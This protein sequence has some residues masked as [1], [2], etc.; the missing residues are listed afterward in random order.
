MVDNVSVWEFG[1]AELSTLLMHRRVQQ[2][3]MCETISGN[4]HTSPY[5]DMITDFKYYLCPDSQTVQVVRGHANS[6]FP[7][8]PKAHTSLTY[9][10]AITKDGS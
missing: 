9:R 1:S 10:H 4:I 5:C 6:S 8:C 3:Q 7:M 2:S